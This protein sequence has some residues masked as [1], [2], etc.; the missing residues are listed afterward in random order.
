MRSSFRADPIKA[1]TPPN[2][3]QAKEVNLSLIASVILA[4]AQLLVL[5]LL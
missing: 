5:A 2:E 4:L 3:A 1:L